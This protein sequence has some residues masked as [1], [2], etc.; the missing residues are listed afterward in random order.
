MIL[1]YPYG[2]YFMLNPNVKNAFLRARLV[3]VLVPLCTAL[4]GCGPN[5]LSIFSPS[6][7]LMCNVSVA[8]LIVVTAP[9]IVPAVL[10]SGAYHK[11]GEAL[12]SH[13]DSVERQ[14]L[15]A[16]VEK[17][18]LAAS[19][20]CLFSCGWAFGE[21]RGRLRRMAAEQVLRESAAQDDL[22]PRQQALSFAAHKVLAD[23]LW[24]EN[25][26]ARIKHLGEALRLG[27]S[28]GMWDYVQA[29]KE[30]GKDRGLPAAADSFSAIADQIVIDLLALKH[31][32]KVQTASDDS[33]PFECDLTVFGRL[34]PL[35][36][37]K[38]NEESKLCEEAKD[39]WKDQQ[40]KAS[41]RSA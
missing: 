31:Q 15:K 14:K 2:I 35:S 36:G 34:I 21:E 24:K 18:E 8:A 39:L 4:G 30:K 25:P 22:S 19:E 23:L 33:L 28:Q 20:E 12:D 26:E 29:K 6:D 17:G 9:V 37:R 16:R 40:R 7:S 5:C 3:T 38:P 1:E 13:K 10:V 11:I 32:A 27:Q 41:R